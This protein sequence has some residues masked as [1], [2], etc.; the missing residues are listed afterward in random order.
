MSSKPYVLIA[1]RG[2]DAS[3]LGARLEREGFETRAV[4]SGRELRECAGSYPVP[5]A[6]VLEMSLPDVSGIEVCREL[7]RSE[8]TR[9]IPV[10][11]LTARTEEVDRVVAFE[12]GASDYLAKPYSLRELALRIRARLRASACE[13]ER[14]KL[15]LDL[16]ANRIWL[17][18]VEIELTPTEGRILG[19]LLT[20]PGRLR[21]RRQLREDVWGREDEV[22]LRAVDAHIGRLRL[23]LGP[24]GMYFEAVH[25]VGY[26]CHGPT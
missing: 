4:G 24:L 12:V 14:D 18:G 9:A 7:R 5:D 20:Q 8:S 11:F 2:E 6:I 10:I 15:K 3:T 21:S 16:L 25:G 13:L 19:V 1:D 17:H 23:K 26:R 22:D